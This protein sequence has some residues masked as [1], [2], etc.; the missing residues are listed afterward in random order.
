MGQ[1]MA[2]TSPLWG[3]ACDTPTPAVSISRQTVA[4]PLPEEKVPSFPRDSFGSVLKMCLVRLPPEAR[5][6]AAS[7]GRE[8]PQFQVHQ[9][10]PKRGCLSK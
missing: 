5:A 2:W 10:G 8:A 3:M 4:L 1:E 6:Q 9:P 7:L